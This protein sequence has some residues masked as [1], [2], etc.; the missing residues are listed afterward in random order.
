MRPGGGGGYRPPSGG[1]GS[2]GGYRPPS[3]G[4]GGSRPPSGGGGGG[5]RPPSGGGTTGHDW[6][7][8]AE[9]LRCPAIQNANANPTIELVCSN[10]RNQWPQPHYAED[11]KY[12]ALVKNGF[13]RFQYEVVFKGS[14]VLVPQDDPEDHGT[15]HFSA[16]IW[17]NRGNRW[18]ASLDGW[19]NI[20]QIVEGKHDKRI[21]LNPADGK[22]KSTW[23]KSVTGYPDEFYDALINP[24]FVAF[25]FGSKTASGHGVDFKGSGS[26][27]IRNITM[28]VEE[29]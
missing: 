17:K 5:Y 16:C 14:P 22:W 10:T 12:P 9:S 24:E 21:S 2:G 29:G 23:G 19:G 18:Y 25:L 1:G 11:Y 7:W 15:S 27:I 4:G 28:T 26:V 3:G 13:L 8:S 20:G 6:R